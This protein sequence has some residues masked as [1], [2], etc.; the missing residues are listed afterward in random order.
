MKSKRPKTIHRT[1]QDTVDEV[2][3]LRKAHG[4]GPNQNRETLKER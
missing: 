1:P 4:W 2:I 3:R